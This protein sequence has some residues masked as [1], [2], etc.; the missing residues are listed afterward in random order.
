MPDYLYMRHWSNGVMSID[1]EKHQEELPMVAH[2]S[3]PSAC[4]HTILTDALILKWFDTHGSNSAWDIAIHLGGEPAG[5]TDAWIVH[6]YCYIVDQ[7]GELED[8]TPV[9][10]EAAESVSSFTD[11]TRPPTPE[12]PLPVTNIPERVFVPPRWRRRNWTQESDDKIKARVTTHGT[13]WRALARYMGGRALGYSDDAVRNRY[14]RIM[15]IT[16][17]KGR[18]VRATPKRGPKWSH[19]EDQTITHLYDSDQH[20][21]WTQ[22]AG[23]LGTERTPA[24][25]RLRAQRL[26]LFEYRG[27][28]DLSLD[29]S[30]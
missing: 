10:S 11:D 29:Y 9:P 6:R 14:M 22:I 8:V 18:Y 17:T 20:N 7:L 13:N 25:V 15:G 1:F 16:T 24:A 19:E 21:R 27:R 5:Y 4:S 26:G 30:G 2:Q 23:H 12:K 3:Y 28:N